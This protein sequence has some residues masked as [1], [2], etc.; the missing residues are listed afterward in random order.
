MHYR[1]F[2]NS[3]I[4]VSEIGLGCEHLQNKSYE[5]VH[6]VL[7]AAIENGINIIDCFMSEPNVRSNIGRAL[8]GRRD[9]VM[10]QGHLRSIWKNGQYGRTLNINEVRNAFEDL[11]N[12]LR[13]DYIDFG[14]I[15]MV[16]S[17]SDFDRIFNGE[18]LEYALHLKEKGVIRKLG[19]SSHNSAV[20][21]KAVQTGLLDSLM[22]SINPAY[23]M[24]GGH[25]ILQPSRNDLYNPSVQGMDPV[26]AQLYRACETMGVGITSMKTLCAGLLLNA[27]KSPLGCAMTP[28]QC[29]HYA[30]SR[31]A[32]ASVM[33]GMQTVPEVTHAAAY[34]QASD[35]DR[36]YTHILTLT[37]SFHTGGSCVYCNHCLPCPANID[38][39]QV[40]KYI[41]LVPE[42][43]SVSPT[44]A[45][46][47]DSLDHKA[48]DCLACGSCENACPFHVP[49]IKRM[50]KAVALFEK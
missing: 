40:N 38:I 15:H 18:I 23:D 43:G 16:D 12:R 7:D 37:P 46:H 34:C 17:E 5:T 48:S 32:V 33:I 29:F 42:N 39:A 11:L 45:A 31:P 44:V 35:S 25:L 49:V 50:K 1:T 20:A 6:Q 13:T 10:I 22:L 9:R 21:L 19:I 4:R 2:G 24:V 27:E 8:E 14:M 36:D 41:D 28:Y 30:L 3:G 47:Y 26:R